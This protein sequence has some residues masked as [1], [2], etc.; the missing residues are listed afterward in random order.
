[1]AVGLSPQEVPEF[2]EQ[3]YGYPAPVWHQGSV[4]IAIYLDLPEH[5][6]SLVLGLFQQQGLYPDY[7]FYK[8]M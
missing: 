8:L 6:T 4:R 5:P 2:V 1:L 7:D 3:Y